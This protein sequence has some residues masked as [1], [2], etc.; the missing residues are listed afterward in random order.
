MRTKFFLLAVAVSLSGALRAQQ[1][2]Y[3]VV[4]V[5]EESGADFTKITSDDDCVSMPLV[6][7]GRRGVSWYT[8]RVLDVSADGSSIAYLS[9]RSD[10]RN[11]FVK[12]L[13]RQGG[14]MQRTNR[15][16]VLE[17]SYS[18]DG[19][20]I[21]FTESD[22]KN[23]HVFQTSAR[24]GYVCRQITAGH[25]DYTPVYASDMTQIF[26]ARQGKKNVGIWSYDI[27]GNFLSNFTSGM[28]PCPVKGSSSVLCARTNS[29]GM[30]EIWKIDYER[31]V[32]E[33]V[34][35]D[36]AKSFTSPQVSPDGEWMLFVG[37]SAIP[38]GDTYYYN[39]DLYVC[40]LDGTGLQ[41]LTYHAA[42]DLSPVWS[43]DGRH[44]Y[45][46]SRRGSATGTA[47]VWRMTFDY[48]Q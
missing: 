45:F 4:S 3:S 25:K 33:C 13:E 47:N 5:K 9:Q 6:K 35:S 2:D 12:D 40:R 8:N 30:I 32:E 48:Q 41:Q 27:K 16:S 21:C 44:V 15:Q 34:V 7:R 31:G 18:P 14:S 22:G 38:Y 46:V 17:F 23:N 36:P 10:T 39:T 1:V 24:T 28:N 26:F 37:S 19:E 43:K 29:R 11:V 42:D 20:S